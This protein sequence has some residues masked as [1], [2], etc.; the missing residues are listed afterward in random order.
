M[1]TMF[2]QGYYYYH[3]S[4]PFSHRCHYYIIYI[5]SPQRSYIGSHHNYD[6]YIITTALSR[7]FTQ[8]FGHNYDSLSYNI[9]I[10]LPPY[11]LQPVSRRTFPFTY[12]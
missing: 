5:S 8:Y 11:Y 2:Q 1:Y 12:I 9:Y 10:K 7:S 6:H 4:D 3:N